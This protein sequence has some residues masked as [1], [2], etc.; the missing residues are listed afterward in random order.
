MYLALEHS[1]YKVFEVYILYAYRA[2]LCYCIERRHPQ[3]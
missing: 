2:C 3:K 1:L